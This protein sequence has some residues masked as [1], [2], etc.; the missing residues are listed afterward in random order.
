[1]CA[2]LSTSVIQIAFAAFFP[3]EFRRIVLI[4]GKTAQ[5]SGQPTPTFIAKVEIAKVEIAK[6]DNPVLI[7]LRGVIPTPARTGFNSAMIAYRES[8]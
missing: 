5:S 8:R 4:P 7:A 2:G 1:M 3:S 6:V